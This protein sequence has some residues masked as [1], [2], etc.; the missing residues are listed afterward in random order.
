MSGLDDWFA[1]FRAGTHT[2]SRGRTA[3]FT[4]ED[5][6]GMV[7][8][9][10][11]EQPSP[12]VITHEELYSPFGYAQVEG[13]R[14]DGDVLQAKCKADSIE[15]QFASLVEDGRLHNRSV[16]ILP[17]SN[18]GYRMGH[19]AFLGAEPPAVEG[20]APIAF[21]TAGMEFNSEQAWEDYRDA[22]TI[23]RIYSVLK[24]LVDKVFDPEDAEAIVSDWEVTHS[25]EEAGARRERAQR[26]ERNTGDQSVKTY[27]QT[28]LDEQL[29]TARAEARAAAERDTASRA[30]I[31]GLVDAGR[32]TP[33]QAE[34]LA[35][36]AQALP[37]GD[38]LEFSRGTGEGQTPEQVKTSPAEFI[39]SL[40]ESLPEKQVVRPP[41][42]GDDGPGRE[43]GQS[44]VAI[45]S[46][47][48][49]FMA[50]EKKRGRII[51]IAQAVRHVTGEAA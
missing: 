26:Q 9:Y 3:S 15:P 30:R 5:L 20:L 12:C 28:E 44:A 6:D 45:R 47:A 37:A 33:A 4:R 13:L 49:E 34:G 19:V 29:A 7:A 11:P 21:S 31:S 24:R 8:A 35:E 25:A 16:Q 42:A 51:G 2:D 27:S 38:V 18:G 1:V 10:D 32:I 36:F 14:R 22:S 50:E 41:L 23:A 39:F 40:L 17:Q 43:S 48:L 46:R